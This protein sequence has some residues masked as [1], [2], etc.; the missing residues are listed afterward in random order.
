M[1]NRRMEFAFPPDVAAIAAQQLQIGDWVCHV[2][3][4]VVTQVTGYDWVQT[5]GSPD[6]RHRIVAYQLDCGISADRV[7]LER[8]SRPDR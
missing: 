4:G 3:T 2:P 7:S 8:A 1:M 6:S 5:F